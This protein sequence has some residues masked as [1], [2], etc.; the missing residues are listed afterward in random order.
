MRLEVLLAPL[1]VWLVLEEMPSMQ[2]LIGGAIIFLTLIGL[3][4]VT[5]RQGP[6]PVPAR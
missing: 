3:S 2:T 6:R 1:W 4:I 5:L